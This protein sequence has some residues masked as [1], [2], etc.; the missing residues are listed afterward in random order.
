MASPRTSLLSICCTPEESE[1][2]T[3]AT[4]EGQI[5]LVL[6]NPN[7]LDEMASDRSFTSTS[8]LFGT[9]KPVARRR[10]YRAPAA[11]P[12]PPPAPVINQIEMIRGNE[13]TVQRME[14][15]Y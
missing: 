9:P 13:R 1:L 15:T 10:V 6:R 4:R 2:L 14:D 3:L 7:D 12:A 5:Q 11:A 8:D